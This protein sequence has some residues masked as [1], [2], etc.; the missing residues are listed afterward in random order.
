MKR[1]KLPLLPTT[2]LAALALASCGSDEGGA[3][4]AASE[5]AAAGDATIDTSTK[6]EVETPAELPDELVTEDIVEGDGPT[7]EPG[8]LVTVQYVGVDASTGEE[9]DSSWDRGQ[10]FSFQLGGGDVIRGWDEGV[11]GMKVGGRRE[12]IIPPNLAYG[13][14][15]S[16]PA[17]APASTLVFVVDL[18]GVG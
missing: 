9:F 7:A 10:P 16:P 14:Q 5:T 13:K 1:N 2:L 8:S 11:E 12:L 15:G 3:T 4:T 17:I 18:L 6:P